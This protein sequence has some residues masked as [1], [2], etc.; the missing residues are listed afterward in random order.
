MV[1]A[2]GLLW[3][4]PWRLDNLLK[5][6]AIC[7]MGPAFTFLS[8]SEK[9]KKIKNCKTPNKVNKLNNKFQFTVRIWNYKKILSKAWLILCRQSRFGH[10]LISSK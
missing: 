8:E 10:M 1:I 6:E 2:L 9:N 3:G 4:K 5:D 7:I